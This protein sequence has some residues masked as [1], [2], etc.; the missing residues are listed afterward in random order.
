[1]WFPELFNRF[2][3]Y[4]QE[5]P[6]QE[7]SV[8][9]VTE[10]VVNKAHSS[11]NET[12]SSTIP[13]SVFMESLVTISAGL[14]ANLIAILFMDRLGR[15]FFLVF[16]TFSAGLC[17]ASMSF[18]TNKS[19]NLMVSAIFSGVISC[20]NAALDCLITEVFPTNLR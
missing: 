20:G 7:T 19:Q 2:E 4:D 1:M 14:P 12:C 18:I 15:K 11:I 3:E 10:F 13:S 8:C 16:S 6:G 9:Q 5:F 17:S